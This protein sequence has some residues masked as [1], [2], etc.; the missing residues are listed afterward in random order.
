LC[1]SDDLGWVISSKESIWGFSHVLGSNT[2]THL[3]VSDDAILLQG[4][5]VMQL[6]LAHIFVWRESQNTIRLFA[7][8]LRF[9]KGQE[10]EK[11]TFVL[12]KLGFQISSWGLEW[13]NTGVILPDETLQLRWTICELG[14]CLAENLI[15]IRLVHIVSLGLA[16]LCSL[17]SLDEGIGWS[18]KFLKFEVTWGRVV[19]KSASDGEIF[20]TGIENNVGWLTLWSTNV[21][22]SHVNSVVLAFKRDLERLLVFLV[23]TGV[24]W[25]RYELFDFRSN[26][27]LLFDL[28][29]CFFYWRWGCCGL[30]QRCARWLF[31]SSVH[32]SH[33][34]SNH[35]ILLI[36]KLGISRIFNRN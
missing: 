29:I 24:S 3:G 5:Q 25:F 12:F 8:A 31:R 13:L 34:G 18:I 27:C 16:P 30:S 2:E 10:L 32:F 15:A 6:L 21:N 1:S 4:P 36:S 23:F 14:R 17:V 19:A 9:V 22:G 26:C 33:G 35:R 7:E 28:C 20:T 11:S